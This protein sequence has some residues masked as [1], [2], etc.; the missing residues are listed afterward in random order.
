MDV[1]SSWT[2]ARADSL[3]RALRMSNE[4][5][6][7]R[8]GAA[9]RTVAYWRERPASVPQ[10]FMQAALDTVLAQAP[11]SVQAQFWLILT[12]RE[13]DRASLQPGLAAGTTAAADD[14]FARGPAHLESS[15]LFGGEMGPPAISAHGVKLITP[16]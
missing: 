8:L 6:A 5:F 9:V 12:E 1:V 15:G 2:G 16:G 11:Q 13:Q 4:A 7:E 10:P 14:K 3:R